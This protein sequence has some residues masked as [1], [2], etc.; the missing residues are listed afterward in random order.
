MKR[1][2]LVLTA[3]A[4]LGVCAAGA[5]DWHPFH[6][7]PQYLPGL[8]YYDYQY[9]DRSAQQTVLSTFGLLLPSNL[10]GQPAPAPGERIRYYQMDTAALKVDHCSL[11]R[12]ALTLHAD[13]TW[14]FSARADQNPLMG[15]DQGQLVPLR[16]D[17]PMVVKFTE[18]LK[19]N[20]FFVKVRGYS[21]YPVKENLPG[22]ST[23]KPAL[24]A[25]TL[26]PFWVQRGEPYDVMLRGQQADVRQ[27]FHLIDRVE[28]EFYYR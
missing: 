17:G 24:A 19:R 4:F 2:H 14:I 20:Q 27:F 13:G 9:R 18:H 28:I 16:P 15:P 26:C 5:A 12:V 6:A 22:V 25:I 23:G 7:R 11:S 21:A 3:A 10:E 1:W 8:P